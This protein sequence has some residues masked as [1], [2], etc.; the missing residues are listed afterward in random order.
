MFEQVFHY[1]DRLVYMIRPRKLVYLAV[2]G[3]APRA[4]I[5]QQRSRRFRAAKEA[6]EK[7]KELLRLVGDTIERAWNYSYI[8]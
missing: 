7:H 3:V 4:K 5:N 8:V 6:E 2:D 1:I